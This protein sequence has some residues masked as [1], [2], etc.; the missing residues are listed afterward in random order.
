M[1]ELFIFRMILESKCERLD[2]VNSNIKVVEYFGL[3]K[4]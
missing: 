3:F 4:C 2:L 1:M